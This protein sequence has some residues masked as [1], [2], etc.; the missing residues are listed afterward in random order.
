M[1]NEE[2]NFGVVGLRKRRRKELGSYYLIS[3]YTYLRRR[4]LRV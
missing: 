1:Q 3:T 2:E 4:S